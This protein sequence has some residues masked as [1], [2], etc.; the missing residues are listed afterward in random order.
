MDELMT[1][2]AIALPATS[3]PT[4][5]DRVR[6]AARTLGC[7]SLW[8]RASGRHVLLGI[9]DAEPFARITPLGGGAHGLAFR[10]PLQGPLQG[11]GATEPVSFAHSKT[12][13]PILLVDL[14]PAVV[15]HALI[16]EGALLR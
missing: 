5:A 15:E 16:G 13:E 3:A 7:T 6:D 12:W 11:E 8:A 14:L 9:G 10:S 1:Q 4:Y 2:V